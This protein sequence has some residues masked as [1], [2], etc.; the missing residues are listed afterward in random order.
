MDNDEKKMRIVETLGRGSTEE[1]IRRWN[2]YADKADD[3]RAGRIEPM[4]NFEKKVL[5]LGWTVTEVVERVTAPSL[6]GTPR[7]RASDRY[8]RIDPDGSVCSLGLD[9]VGVFAHNAMADYCLKY[10]DDLGDERIR[11]ILES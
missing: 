6:T 2:E 9:P 5:E 10:N 3:P 4:K 7:F 1:D 11:K 8:F